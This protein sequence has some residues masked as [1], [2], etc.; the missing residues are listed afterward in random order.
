MAE[1][2]SFWSTIPGLITGIAAIV[3]GLVALVPI[4][5]KVTQHGTVNQPSSS[6]ALPPTAS[7]GSAGVSDTASP[8]VSSAPGDNGSA[9]PGGDANASA[10]AG[11]SASLT[12]TPST[13]DFGNVVSGQASADQTVTITNAGGAAATLDAATITGS[14]PGQFTISSSTCGTGAALGPQQTCQVSLRFTPHAVG[15]ASATLSVG[16]HPP[17]GTVTVPLTGT[18]ALL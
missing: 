7:P 3:T 10:P 14:N 16:F 8:L 4:A 6:S 9:T 18:G 1:K 15:S 5:L 13:L 2:K 11:G 17:A 12:A